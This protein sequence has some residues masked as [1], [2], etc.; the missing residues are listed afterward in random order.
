MFLYWSFISSKRMS[1]LGWD[2]GE[3][4]DGA[5]YNQQKHQR[6]SRKT[7]IGCLLKQRNVDARICYHYLVSSKTHVA[8][9]GLTMTGLF[10]ARYQLRQR[11]RPSTETANN[12][13]VGNLQSNIVTKKQKSWCR[14]IFFFIITRFNGTKKQC[15][16]LVS[17]YAFYQ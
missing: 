2:V 17:K 1:R 12:S 9:I 16:R 7:K 13:K 6:I 14:L 11:Q 15:N 5:F 10:S 8:R 4:E 3:W